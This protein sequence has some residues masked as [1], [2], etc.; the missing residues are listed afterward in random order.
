ME[1]EISFRD[2]EGTKITIALAE[3]GDY[4]VVDIHG[5]R[6]PTKEEKAS[7]HDILE[8]VKSTL[9]NQPADPYNSQR[10]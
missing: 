1:R 8:S 5:K 9:L 3:N 4:Q 7:L 10:K 6:N 2:K